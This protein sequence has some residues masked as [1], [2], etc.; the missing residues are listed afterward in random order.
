MLADPGLAL[1]WSDL[2]F[3]ATVVP[4]TQRTDLLTHSDSLGAPM[5]ICRRRAIA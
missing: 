4:F 2:D 5:L 1:S 3:R